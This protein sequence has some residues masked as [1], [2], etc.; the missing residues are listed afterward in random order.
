MTVFEERRRGFTLIEL[1]VVIAIIGVLVALL[2]PAVQSARESARRMQCVNNLKQLGLATMNYEG[3]NGSLPP[4]IVVSAN[5][6]GFWTNGW[7]VNG[8]LLPFMEQ[9]AA[10]NATNFTLSYGD[11]SNT[12]IGALSLSA[13]LCP[14]EVQIDPKPS[15]TSQYGVANY[16]WN[17]GDWYVWGGLGSSTGNRGAFGVNRSRRLAEFLDGM[18]NTLLASEVKTYQAVLSKCSLPSVSEPGSIPSPLADPYTAVPE[19]QA[20]SCTLKTTAHAEW[21]DGQ[22]LETGFTTAWPPN[23]QILAGGTQLDV[24]IVGV[25]EKSGGPTYAAVTARSYHPGGVNALFGDGSVHFV[26]SSISGVTWRSLGSVK[27]GEVVSSD[28]Y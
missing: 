26:K 2:L 21:V 8:R 1:L 22:V 17:M 6:S 5:G 14:S 3:V 10:F 7:S 25:G 4:S 28:S 11:P 12:T 16:N 20:A 24:D 18:S 23:K 19:Y 9:Y 13:L 27:G 15:K